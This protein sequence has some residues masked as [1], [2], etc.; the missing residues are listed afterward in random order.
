M[1]NLTWSPFVVAALLVL[2]GYA[3]QRT[4][5]CAVR[6][7]RE[8]IRNRRAH[9][10]A[11]FALAA[12]TAMLT[13]AAARG[14]GIDAFA[15]IMARPLTLAAVG[16]GIL[17]GVGASL[18]GHCAMGT[19]AALTAG[20]LSRLA[21]LAAMVL[22]ALWAMPVAAPMAMTLASPLAAVTPATIAAIAAPAALLLGWYIRV[23]AGTGRTRS[24]WPPL[25]AML[26]IGTA[27]GLLFAL[28]AHWP[29]TGFLVELAAGHV[30]GW[31][32]GAAGFAA[33]ITGML[34]ATV[35][36]GRWRMAPGNARQWT[37][38]AAGGLL[39]GGGAAMVPGG[40][41]AMLFTGVPLLLPNMIAA[42]AAFLITVAAIELLT[43][44]ELVGGGADG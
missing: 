22:G 32:T 37:R 30:A 25:A 4:S 41:D 31:Q 16:G 3:S 44:R 24:G 42:Y 10:M 29:Y 33:V 1:T 5:V 28:D 36:A 17:F 14:F 43:A 21:T 7:V 8:F 27:S 35:R 23:R 13:M 2:I 18:N 19:L 38:A 9:R 40:N 11:G 39:M 34:I 15:A 26:V 20:D 12:L 6:G